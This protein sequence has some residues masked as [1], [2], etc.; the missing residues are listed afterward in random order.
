MCGFYELNETTKKN[1]H[2]WYN[3]FEKRYKKMCGDGY[4]DGD[5]FEDKK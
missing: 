5:F 1:F 4:A 2:N 3:L